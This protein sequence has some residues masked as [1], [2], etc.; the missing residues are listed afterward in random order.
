MSVVHAFRWKYPNGR[1]SWTFR[2]RED[3]MRHKPSSTAVLERN[4]GEDTGFRW[5]T[6]HEA[7]PQ[8]C[9]HLSQEAARE[10][11]TCAEHPCTC[12]DRDTTTNGAS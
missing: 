1:V 10:G 8:P 6:D 3:A 12:T 4:T 5:V 11:R 2:T 9:E 7:C